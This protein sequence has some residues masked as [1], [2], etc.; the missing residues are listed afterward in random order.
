MK[1]P[2]LV[3]IKP[4][5]LYR[6]LVGDIINKFGETGLDLI[7]L[8]LVDVPRQRAAEHYKQLNDKPFFNG[9][10]NHLMGKYHD[11]CRVVVMVYYGRD[12]IRK[13]R[14]VAGATNPEEADP[15]SIRGSFGRITKKGIFENVVHVSSDS[16]EA[17]REIFLWL[18]PKDF[19]HIP[20][21]TKIVKENN[22]QKRVWK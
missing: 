15:K 6:S 9:V 4:E 1:T 17:K 8:K 2:A 12:A 10:I 20:Y 18:E 3:I 16:E 13:C 7:A 14:R 21:A 5:G 22:I 19:A 11:G